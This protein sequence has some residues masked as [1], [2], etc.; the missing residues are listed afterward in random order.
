MNEETC[1]KCGAVYELTRHKLI[2]RDK[3]SINCKCGEELI[4]WNGGVCYSSKLIKKGGG[5]S[6]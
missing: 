6:T 4:S 2:A 1:K 3:D 5:E